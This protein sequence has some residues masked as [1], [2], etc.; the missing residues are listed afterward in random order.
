MSHCSSTDRGLFLMENCTLA[1]REDCRSEDREYLG[2]A[3]SLGSR[4]G[5][6]ELWDRTRVTRGT[7]SLLPCQGNLSIVS[8][9]L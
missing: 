5:G 1:F 7:C 2:P 9:Q 6:A 8:L 3:L 4:T